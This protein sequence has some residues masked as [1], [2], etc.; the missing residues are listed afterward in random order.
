MRLFVMMCALMV[1]VMPQAQAMENRIHVGDLYNFV[2]DKNS[3]VNNPLISVSRNFLNRTTAENAIF[4]NRVALHGAA[5]Q[6]HRVYHAH[7]SHW[8][9]YRYPWSPYYNPVSMRSMSK[10]DQINMLENK[11]RNIP[12]Y[13]AR[14]D[15]TNTVINPYGTTAIVDVDLKE[16]SLAYTPYSPALTTRVLHANSKCKM[17]LSRMG[18]NELV[19]TRMDCNT[20][21]NLP[22]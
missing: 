21:T 5:H 14:I 18:T 8:A 20:N 17:Y 4:E 9:Y 19:M 3:A 22:M 16:Y 1:M 2:S 13:Q 15:I 7:P 10:W 11:K 12:G 6:W